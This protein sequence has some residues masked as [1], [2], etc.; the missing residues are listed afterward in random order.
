[1]FLFNS[2]FNSFIIFLWS[3]LS[4]YL[5]IHTLGVASTASDSFNK[6]PLNNKNN[7]EFFSSRN[8]WNEDYYQRNSNNQNRPNNNQNRNGGRNNKYQ[9]MQSIIQNRKPKQTKRQQLLSQKLQEL[10]ELPFSVSRFRVARKLMIESRIIATKSKL[11]SGAYKTVLSE[12]K[13]V[14]NNPKNVLSYWIPPQSFKFSIDKQKMSCWLILKKSPITVQV[15]PTKEQRSPNWSTNI[16]T[17]WRPCP[18]T[19]TKKTN[20]WVYFLLK[21]E[22]FCRI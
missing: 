11:A 2:L 16:T 5:I 21:M 1:M 18:M 14:R 17:N 12:L 6:K 15:S 9:Q 3:S 7:N 22:G 8:K 19:I 4:P 13:M 10:S 20:L